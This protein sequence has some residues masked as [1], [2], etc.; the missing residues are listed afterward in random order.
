M[1]IFDTYTEVA[2]GTRLTGPGARV[3]GAGDS[4]VQLIGDPATVEVHNGYAHTTETVEGTRWVA[5]LPVSPDSAEYDCFITFKILTGSTNSEVGCAINV[6]ANG[7]GY[8]A[9][10]RLWDGRVYLRGWI[11]GEVTTMN[12]VDVAWAVGEEHTIGV[13]RTGNTPTLVVDPQV[14][15]GTLRTG[16]DQGVGAFDVGVP[17][18][19]F[20]GSGTATAGQALKEIASSAYTA[21]P[22]PSPLAGGTIAPGTVTSTSVGILSS[23][24]AS[25]GTAPVAYQWQRKTGAGAF[26]NLPGATLAALTDWTVGPNTSYTYRRQAT[27]SAAPAAVEYSNEL[28]ITT[29]ASPNAPPVPGFT[30][31]VAEKTVTV[32][33]TA[34]DGDGAI[35]NTEYDYTNGGAGPWVAGT[36]YT[37]PVGGARTVWQRVTDDGGASA[38]TS[39]ALVTT[40]AITYTCTNVVGGVESAPSNA[41]IVYR[42]DA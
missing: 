40:T 5:A 16:G 35:V 20:R 39:V 9:V 1:A 27:D 33:S 2:D 3:N 34:G 31:A 4:L 6:Q 15:G 37:Y 25:G 24:D 38:T 8:Y 42:P 22:T 7:D 28:P 12:F 36:S 13:T 11:G 21:T 32:A 18:V 19:S 26:A 29:A 41:R 23:A 10:Y 30:V 17:V 14:G